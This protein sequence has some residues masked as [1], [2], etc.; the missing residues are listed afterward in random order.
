MKN[1]PKYFW[2][3]ASAILALVAIF[4]TYNV[5][6]LGRPNKELQIIIEQPVSLVDVKPE[7]IQDIQVLY[8]E[9]P[10]NKVFLLQIHIVN[11]G[12]QPISEA[13]Y[14]RPLSFNFPT[15]YKLADVAVTS[16][17]PANI[18]MIISKLSEQSAV[19]NKTLLNP[20]DSVSVSFILI[21]DNNDDLISDFNIDGRI[22][23]VKEIKL[24][25][26]SEQPAKDPKLTS[27]LWAG[28]VGVFSNFFINSLM[29]FLT[30]SQKQS[31]V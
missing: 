21:G 3:I 13:D 9:E 7:A 20:N 2:Q 12:N 19:A 28:L 30:P 16:S 15:Q 31:L 24:I 4:S 10:V 17:S 18:G 11:S 8:K 14:S 25:S 29:K 26:P 22:F 27:L 1:L 5:F 23:G 6:F